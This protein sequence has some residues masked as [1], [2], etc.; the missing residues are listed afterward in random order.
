MLGDVI[1]NAIGIAYVF[2]GVFLSGRL[3][4]RTSPNFARTVL[5]FAMGFWT[6]TWFLYETRICAIITPIIATISLVLASRNIRG[7]FSKERERHVGLVFYSV[8]V[9]WVT[10]LF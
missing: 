2:G 5:H 10:L 9:T 4:E 1:G 6:F 8:S 3:E 7:K